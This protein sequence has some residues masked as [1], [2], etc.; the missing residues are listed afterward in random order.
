MSILD[1]FFGG[2][3]EREYARFLPIVKEINS[4]KEEIEALSDEDLKKETERFKEEL[5]GGK[6]LEDILPRAYAVVRESA[7]RHLGEFHYDVQ[8]VGGIVLHHRN[9]SEMRTGEGKTLVATLPAYLNALTEKGVH[10]VTV[11][12]YLARRD[13]TWMGQ[14]YS[15]LGLSI[16]VINN[17][18]S[19]LYDPAHKEGSEEDEERDDL[20]SFKVSYEFLRPCSRKE[21]YASDITYG[22]NNEFGFD[23]LRD[24][25]EYNKNELRQ[26][27][28]TF[29]IID[30][31][32]SILI[33]EARTPLIISAPAQDSENIYET[34]TTIARGLKKEEDYTVDEKLKAITL[35]DQGIEKSERLLGVDNIY[36]E[37][38]M[39]YVHHLETAVRAKALFEKDKQYVV[40]ND[41]VI[42]VDEFTGRL[43]PGRRWSDGLHQAIEAK[44]GV[45]I[46]K[47]SRT[48]ASVTFQNY[49]RMYEKL[50]G[51]TGTAFTSQEEF[52]TVYGLDVYQ[53]PTNQ[54]I[55]RTDHDDLI[56]QTEQG[57]FKA[58][59]KKVKELNEKGQPVLIGTVSI[60]NNERLSDFLKKEN[61]PHEALNAKNHEREA[62]IIAQAGEKGRVTIATNMA[63]RGVDIKLGGVPG[64]KEAYE[65][66][67]SLGGLFVIGTE[68]HEA[69]RID[70]QLRGRSGRQGDPG[71]TQFFVSL[72]DTL[73]RVFATDT[74]KNMMG[75]FKIPEDQP[76]HNK[77]ITRS[78]E[79]AQEKIEGFNFDSRKHVLSYDN[80]LNHQR[81][82]IYEKRNRA[83]L[84][85]NEDVRDL[86]IEISGGDEEIEAT[87]KEKE[88]LLGVD[89]FYNSARM[90]ILQV[91]DTLWVEHLE[92]MDYLRGSVNLRAY[93]QRD[94]LIEYRKE[95]LRMFRELEASI[96]ERI[97]KTL[98]NIGGN[99]FV[100][101]KK[102]LQEVHE[103]ARLIG[104][105]SNAGA[106]QKQGEKIGRN[107]QVTITNGT[108]EKT[109][110]Y[111]KAEQLLTTGEWKLKI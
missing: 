99:A 80:V 110:K 63:G 18:A 77:I 54:P 49:F 20:G 82:A 17:Q 35:T 41:E 94:P 87:L 76:I 95:G 31:I 8:L 84:G 34:F 109:M 22:T 105:G 65:E 96:D 38:G 62:E 24:N 111:K 71:E 103:N 25:L 9:I 2:G 43:Q 70:N 28:H 74:V 61:V 16:G 29:A 48:Y 19:Y 56:F 4:F 72:E 60:E 21:A 101:E 92:G 89:A 1:K 102:K 23:Y 52:H 27:G 53:V 50:A 75:R 14:V 51:M 55:A 3:K 58:V 15:A 59:A 86:L 26:R 44:E 32:D 91:I 68:R 100:E 12:D 88:G 64:S 11:N 39:K 78:L 67:K 106:S 83:L 6:A 37:R 66:V 107:E 69:R 57:K 97:L 45:T 93:G 42:I 79:R 36:T 7:R 90:V 46:Q 73:M 13:A 30:E 81:T 85:G 47:E 33:D 40:K 108:E 98:P 10:I 5:K 104:Q